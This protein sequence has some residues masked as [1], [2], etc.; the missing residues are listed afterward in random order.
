MGYLIAEM[1]LYLL[2]AAAIGFLAAWL[3]RSG[4]AKEEKRSFSHQVAARPST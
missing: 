1:V 4:L 3:I 2:I